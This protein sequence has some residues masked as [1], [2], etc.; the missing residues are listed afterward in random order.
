MSELAAQP[1]RWNLVGGASVALATATL[2]AYGLAAWL[3]DGF[4]LWCG[5]A[6]LAAFLT[7]RKAR[8]TMEHGPARTATLLATIVGALAAA[9]V[10][11]YSV[12]FGISHL[13]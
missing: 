2:V 4:Y 11:V 10:I 13:V 1:R 5:I 8:K 3:D 9:V 7:G 12:A 6:G